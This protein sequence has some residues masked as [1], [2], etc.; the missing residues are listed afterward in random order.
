MIF[1]KCVI[2]DLLTSI[3][4]TNLINYVSGQTKISNESVKEQVRY[5]Q[6]LTQKHYLYN[7]IAGIAQLYADGNIQ[8]I[9]SQIEINNIMQSL[10]PIEQYTVK[11]MLFSV[12]GI[13]KQ[14][15]R[16][17]YEAEIK[18][19]EEQTKYSREALQKVQ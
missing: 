4:F 1:G 2:E 7:F 13:S 19:H 17:Y 12:P 15:I 8:V 3:Y 16:E 18:F 5:L 10:N 14:K 9:E 11:K 6:L